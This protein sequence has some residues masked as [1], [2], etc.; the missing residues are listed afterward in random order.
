M[1]IAQRMSV[2]VPRERVWDFMMDVPAVGNCVPGVESIAEQPDGSYVGVVRVSIGPVAARLE[3][4][5]T[6]AERDR[7]AW[8]ARM[9]IRAADRRIGGTVNAKVSMELE[10]RADGGTDVNLH[11]D[12]AILGRLGQFGQAV[13]KRQ[14]DQLMAGFAKNMSRAL[15]GD[16]PTS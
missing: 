15:A 10:S 3:G 8:R 6:L 4:V 14:A 1:I 5:L 16:G 13:I 7:E 12:A 9:D 11:T 2:D